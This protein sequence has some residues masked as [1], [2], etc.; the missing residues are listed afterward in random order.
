MCKPVSSNFT[1]EAVSLYCSLKETKTN[2]I[3][4]TGCSF[5]ESPV[6]VSFRFRIKH[7]IVGK[8]QILFP[9]LWAVRR[10]HVYV[11]HE[12]SKICAKPAYT[13]DMSRNSWFISRAVCHQTRQNN[14]QNRP[15][16]RLQL[17]LL[18]VETSCGSVSCQSALEWRRDEMKHAV[19]AQKRKF[20]ASLWKR[21]V[22]QANFSQRHSVVGRKQAAIP[23]QPPFPPRGVGAIQHL[24]DVP[25]AET[26]LVIFLSGEV[27]Q[28]LHLHWAR[29]LRDSRRT[30][31]EDQHAAKRY[32]SFWFGKLSHLLTR[33]ARG[34]WSIPQPATR[35]LVYIPSMFERRCS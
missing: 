8:N 19:C 1:M 2:K 29:P 32:L 21:F 35:G 34:L 4:S 20:K 17:L 24:D 25:G 3:I 13:Y 33:R 12:N 14:G 22:A 16:C 6:K 11:M 31:S 28:R 26:Q 10:L 18:I 30:Q 23:P 27:I 15:C 7:Q 9:I 5:Y